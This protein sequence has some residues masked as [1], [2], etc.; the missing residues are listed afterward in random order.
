LEFFA[1]FC[2]STSYPAPYGEIAAYPKLGKVDKHVNNIDQGGDQAKSIDVLINVFQTR[3]PSR[4]TE[5]ARTKA[6]C[7]TNSS[8]KSFEVILR[9]DSYD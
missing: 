6:R 3:N 8:H 7:K 2:Q 1:W 4:S 5:D 9:F